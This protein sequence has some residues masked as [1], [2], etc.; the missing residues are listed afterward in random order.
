MQLLVGGVIFGYTLATQESHWRPEMVTP[1]GTVNVSD[2]GLACRPDRAAQAPIGYMPH[3]RTRVCQTR[4]HRVGRGSHLRHEG[5]LVPAVEW[6]QLRC[7]ADSDS[8]P[9]SEPCHLRSRLSLCHSRIPSLALLVLRMRALP[10]P[11]RVQSRGQTGGLPGRIEV[12]A[13]AHQCTSSALAVRCVR[14]PGHHGMEEVRGSNPLSSTHYFPW[15]GRDCMGVI[16]VL[17]RVLHD[18]GGARW[19]HGAS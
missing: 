6:R 4:V 12:A 18:H 16:S 11:D 15:S 13:P 7:C 19:P 9:T 5:D 8:W 1:T 17:R 3:M 10:G 14:F 2:F